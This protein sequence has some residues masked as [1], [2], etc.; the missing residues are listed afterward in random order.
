MQSSSGVIA[1]NIFIS[2][3]EDKYR[4]HLEN[5]LSLAGRIRMQNDKL[6]TQSQISKMKFTN[7]KYEELHCR[8][9]YQMHKHKVG[10]NQ[11]SLN[12]RK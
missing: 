6:K 7:D 10:N 1:V 11:L 8:G 2:D 4:A 12:T 3:L 9:R 5:V